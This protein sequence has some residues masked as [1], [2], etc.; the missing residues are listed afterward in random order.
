M[1]MPTDSIK[2]SQLPALVTPTA[3]DVFPVVSGGATDKASPGVFLTDW[4][5]IAVT[6]TISAN[7]GQREHTILYAGIDLTGVIPVGARLRIPRTGSTPTQGMQFILASSQYASKSGPAGTTFTNN[8]TVEAWVYLDGAVNAQSVVSRIGAN[9]G[10]QLQ[11]LATGQVALSGY[12]ASYS[13]KREVASYQSISTAR[14]THIAASL[15][16]SG[17]TTATNKVFIDGVDAVVSL[18][19]TGTNPTA[20][21]QEGSL[22]IGAFNGANNLLNGKVANA[23]VWSAVRTAAQIRDNMNQETPASTT[24]LVAWFKG[25]GNFND[26]SS[27]ANNL[28]AQGGAIATYADNPYKPTEYAIVTKL[29]YSGGNTT[30]T[31]FTGPCA[32][33][34][35]TLGVTSYSTVRTPLG[36]PSA[37]SKWSLNFIFKVVLAGLPTSTTDHVFTGG[38]MSFPLGE[39]ILTAPRLPLDLYKT[40]SGNFGFYGLGITDGSTLDA[41]GADTT[42]YYNFSGAGQMIIPMIIG[43]SSISTTSQTTYKMRGSHSFTD[44]SNF[45]V[46]GDWGDGVRVALE[47][48]YL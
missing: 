34:N 42:G 24:N 45:A 31:I 37:R 7:N 20:L 13:N 2:I 4:K 22:Q 35:E 39:W 38:D 32:I 26:S 12:N 30:A 10:W 15:D 3:S 28:T 1:V 17:W 27:N 19:S 23:R 48:A 33:P 16:M 6:P 8:F 5:D 44:Y 36:F 41:S 47:C 40:S 21:V 46:R 14:W 25:N 11:I 18:T 29:S 9:Q 43:R